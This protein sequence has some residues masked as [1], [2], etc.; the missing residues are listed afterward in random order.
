MKQ[1]KVCY[2]AGMSTKQQT[3]LG[4]LMALLNVSLAD[5]GDY[6]FVAQTSISKWRTGARALGPSS[7]HFD[8]IVE[9]FAMLV[10]DEPRRAKMEQLFAQLYPDKP[11]EKP[12]DYARCL[13]TFLAGNV[14]P[15][16]MVRQAI[17]DE[18]RLYT[19]QV[20]VFSGAEG[21]AAALA[22]FD[23]FVRE[24]RPATVLVMDTHDPA[25]AARLIPSLG[26][27]HRMH[28]LAAPPKAQQLMS[29]L[30]QVL[31]CGAAEVR[32]LPEGGICPAG[33]GSYIAGKQLSL[34][35]YTP[36]GH[37]SYASVHTDS[38]TIE[39][40]R[41]QFDTL[42]RNA[43]PAMEIMEAGY[44]HSGFSALLA[45]GIAQ[46]RTEFFLP[47]LPYFTMGSTL[48]MEV[49]EAHDVSGRV[50]TRVLEGY[51][52]LLGLPV[53]IYIP[54]GALEQPAEVLP[55]L[56][57]ACGRDM[58]LS[59]EQIKRHQLSTAALLRADSGVQVVPVRPEL[60][61]QVRAGMFV[62]RNAV[63]GY[64]D[65]EGRTVR[66]MRHPRLV[67]AFMQAMDT[68]YGSVTEGLRDKAYIASILEG[69]A[70]KR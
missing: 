3:P 70:L 1:E 20:G 11:L 39:Y 46:E 22:Q 55:E 10:R 61:A 15:S 30:S 53:R 35:C 57:M 27:E 40:H 38:L 9:Y 28:V 23:V 12:Q 66:L 45:S 13:R 34:S 54:A 14:M 18:G 2:T 63:G 59:A 60:A 7:Q 37:P 25:A 33:T 42:W 17:G 58:R 49:L 68:L 6:L 56:S 36:P 48:L 50:W 52:M 4:Y 44:L 32:L 29:P 62:K 21:M 31:T 26:K 64:L 51:K 69:T 47:T 43:E 65:F 41:I 67:E 19:T 16:A 24:Q 8:G 5:L